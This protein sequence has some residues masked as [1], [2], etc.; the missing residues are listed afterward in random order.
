MGELLDGKTIAGII[1]EET[2]SEVE[3][4]GQ[5]QGFAPGLAVVLVGDDPASKV[6][7]RRISNSC[8][9]TGIRLERVTL[10]ADC[11]VA[12]LQSTLRRLG[13]DGK[14]SGIIVQMP[15]PGALAR[16]GQ[17]IVTEA[18]PPNKDVDG[19]HPINTGLLALGRE[20]FVPSTPLGG[21]ELLRRYEINL[22]GLEAVVVGRSAIVGK[23]MASLLINE[24]ATVTVCHSRTRDLPSVIR[25][26]DLVA[27][28]IGKAKMITGDMIK[29][30]AIVIDFGINPTENGIVGDVD[31]ESAVG[32]ASLIT[33]TPG[34][35][36]P[37]TN[38]MLMRNT[39][40]AARRLAGEC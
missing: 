21:L 20:S 24:H 9:E 14:T 1:R 25:R 18:L 39:L 4:F 31:F 11:D 5:R 29:P 30:G 33:P 13:Q 8:K 16:H 2:K 34:G 17:E 19:L 27:V 6:Y 35:T 22:V 38:A 36:G 23:P 7:V 32:V 10:S 40:W 15:L 37:M 28:A 3:A 12:D 26:A